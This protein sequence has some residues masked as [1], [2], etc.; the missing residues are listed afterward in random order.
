MVS[1]LIFMDKIIFETYQKSEHRNS[2]YDLIDE[3]ISKHF[4]IMFNENSLDYELWDL[5]TSRQVEFNLASLL[6]HLNREKIR[7]NRQTFKTYLE[8]HFVKRYNP[9]RNYFSKLQW[10]GKDN[11]KRFSSYV[12]TDDNYLFY[13]HLKK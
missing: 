10:N 6:I 1:N 12:N 11:I 5:E 9:I 4:E 2:V 3:E 8:S 7:A 13:H